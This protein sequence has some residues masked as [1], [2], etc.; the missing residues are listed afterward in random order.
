MKQNDKGGKQYWWRYLRPRPELHASIAPLRRVLV[1]VQTSKYLSLGF[2][3][4]GIVYSHM[5]VVLAFDQWRYFAL[6]NT[7]MH[8]AWVI[9]YASTLETRMRYIPSDCFN[10]FPFPEEVTPLE[11]IGETYH[12]TRRQIMLDRWEGLTDT[13]NRFHNPNEASDDIQHLR[14]LHVEM[15][16]AVAAAYGWEDLDLAHG[17]HETAQGVRFTISEA[18]RREVLTR[19][20]KLNHERYAQECHDGLHKPKDCAAFFGEHPEHQRRGKVD[21]DKVMKR[22]KLDDRPEQQELFDD[23]NPQKRLF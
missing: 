6:L 2:Q 7:N 12:E 3:P 8:E 23:D 10:T 17:F 19:L 4:I 13:Y 18:A 20:L 9:S 16:Y 14:E 22:K 1:A 11:T 21:W 15:D 5:T